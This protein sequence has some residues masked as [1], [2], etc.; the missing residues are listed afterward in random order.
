[1]AKVF[2]QTLLKSEEKQTWRAIFQ[3]SPRNS[4]PVFGAQNTE[5]K[6]NINQ[7]TFYKLLSTPERHPFSL[8][9]GIFEIRLLFDLTPTANT[10]A[11]SLGDDCKISVFLRFRVSPLLKFRHSTGFTLAHTL[12]KKQ[13][14][15]IVLSIYFEIK[16]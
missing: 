16:L 11:K 14:N 2:S 6:N 10:F 5:L 13:S 9:L 1:M 12:S 7:I 4:Y 8:K 15:T 3:T